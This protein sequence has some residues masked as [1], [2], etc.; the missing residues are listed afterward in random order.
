MN[1]TTGVKC[2]QRVRYSPLDSDPLDVHS[3]MRAAVRN[4]HQE[5]DNGHHSVVIRVTR[6]HPKIRPMLAVEHGV[7]QATALT[8]C[9]W[10]D[11]LLRKIST[12]SNNLTNQG[13]SVAA[14]E[15][16][17]LPVHRIEQDVTLSL[18]HENS[19]ILVAS[20]VSE[21]EV[22]TR[23]KRSSPRCPK[24]GLKSPSKTRHSTCISTS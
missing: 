17:V 13:L 19:E 6:V 16:R 5:H 8:L 20:L 1:L 4:G 23:R 11:G 2:Y 14:N 12:A 10:A 22:G 9:K 15:F 3:R 24:Q 21:R 18:Y 7:V